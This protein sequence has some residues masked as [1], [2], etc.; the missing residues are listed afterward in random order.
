MEGIR[1]DLRFSVRMLAKR[2]GFTLIALIALGLG[3]GAN[4]AIF[5]V[6]NA[7]LLRE[8]PFRDPDR[9][10]LVWASKPM[11][12]GWPDLPLS[13]PNFNDVRQQ[14]KSF[15]SMS[16]WTSG[17]FNLTATS[18]SAIEP[19]KVQYSIV[20]ANL[21]STLGV[22]PALGRDF[23]PSEDERGQSR[24]ILISNSLWQRRFGGDREILGKSITLDG[25]GYEVCGVLPPSFRFVSFPR[26][27]DIWLPLGLDTFKERKYV[28]GANALGV[29]G[30]LEPGITVEQ[31]R[32]E[33]DTISRRLRDT[34]PEYNKDLGLRVVPLREQAIQNLRPA[35]VALLLAVG[36]L[37][38]IACANVAN[39][40]LTRAKGR[41]NEIAIR[42]ALGA[43]RWRIARQL[44]VENVVLGT[45]GGALG[46]LLALWC[47]ELLSRIP[48]NTPDLFTP[49][50]V[51]PDQIGVD[52]RVL[53]VAVALSLVTGVLF[54][55][56]PILEATRVDLQDALKDSGARMLSGALRAR[57]FLVV[58]EVA[59]A[60]ILLVGAGLMINSFARLQ[61]V[62]PGFDARNTMKFDISL[63]GSRY[64]TPEKVDAFY[65]RLNRSLSGIPSVTAVGAVEYLPLGG[66]D[67]S[68]GLLFEGQP[69][70]PPSER[71]KVHSRAATADYFGAMGIPLRDGRSFADTDRLDSQKVA[72]VNEALARR[73]WP[74]ESPLG[75]RIALDFESMRYYRDRPPDFDLSLGLREVVGVVGD[76]KHR[77]LDG[78]TFP[79]MYVPESQRPGRDMT[80][81]MRASSD[82]LALIGEVRRQVASID[83]DQPV[84]NVDEMEGVVAASVAQP[85]FN[86]TLLA[87]F[88]GMALALAA[89]GIY[90]VISYSVVERTREIGIRMALGARRGDVV[91]MIVAQGLR[92]TA[93]GVAIGVAGA[94][95]LTR[96]MSSLLYNVSP[97]DPRTFAVIALLLS[98]V[99]T[100][101][102]LIP[103]RRATRVDPMAAL[104]RE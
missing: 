46:L 30:R 100:A 11:E 104:R 15:S 48:Y 47:V 33:L 80:V 102:C 4:T 20:S 29:I 19:E 65:E 7:I 73:F 50:R 27:T 88:G 70:P 52:G 1:T 54:G 81:V 31:A 41:K 103:A 66:T 78:E 40:Q 45:A 101:A 6:V 64:D 69:I 35:L 22:Q 58:G 49:Y 28:R 23:V 95:A 3:I 76:V 12:E 34:Y 9:L 68:T 86:A 89:V 60:M 25:Q 21:L 57:G 51:A 72:I 55:L 56:V 90:G 37:L 85:R 18:V 74:N 59:L 75:R 83:R 10:M 24:A 82:P 94:L 93:A 8:P 16:V 87:L 26:E 77:R 71:P 98:S 17:F 44:L 67:Q 43:G 99:A 63:P 61:S 36:F 13:L 97:T 53:L 38:L 84:A 5:S 62:D 2:P 42:A 39:L 79:E 96:F 91:G 14:S 92:L 32:S